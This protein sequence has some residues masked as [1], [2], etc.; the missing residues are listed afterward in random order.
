M[1]KLIQ[2]LSTMVPIVDSDGKPTPQFS[3]V[4]QR[5][6]VSSNLTATNG[7]ID[8]V[9][10]AT[11]MIIANK[12]A[13]SATPTACSISDILDFLTS[14]RGSIIFRGATGWQ[15]LAPGTGG[16]VLQTNGP[17]ADPTWV[18]PAAGGGNWEINVPLSS[19]FTKASGDATQLSMTDSTDVGIYI[20]CGAPVA[21]QVS[22]IAYKTLSNK[23]LAWTVT[24]KI[25]AFFPNVTNTGGGVY[26]MDS[27][28]GRSLSFDVL[29]DGSSAGVFQWSPTLIG[30]SS[31]PFSFVPMRAI[32]WVR[33]TSDGTTLSFQVSESGKQFVEYSNQAI[34]SWLTNKPDRIGFGS[35][36]NR[37]GGI[38]NLMTVNYFTLT[39]PGV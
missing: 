14:T 20:D 36:T 7:K 39:G 27:I 35:N 2:P 38:K 29:R 8:V 18:T 15:A 31:S 6:S 21:G 22:R 23:A 19:T 10:I 32:E 1:T 13:G 30:F 24:V 33:I 28:S 9:A 3:R 11:H 37:A 25:K 26:L 34:A 16:N 4:L 17:G 5:L 12:T